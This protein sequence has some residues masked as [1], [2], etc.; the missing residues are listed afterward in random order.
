MGP[1]PESGMMEMKMKNLLVVKSGA[2]STT[3]N[4]WKAM[5]KA[6]VTPKDYSLKVS[7]VEYSG[8]KV[9]I[10]GGGHVP[11]Y[12]YLEMPEGVRWFAGCFAAGTAIEVVDPTP[13]AEVKAEAPKAP[14]A[15][16]APKAPE[17]K[18]PAK[19]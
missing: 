3:L 1:L 8:S 13:K 4:T 6:S 11:V 15:P 2:F 19:K 12:T 5:P 16:E 18:K 10:T 9:M 7:G 17:V 14:E